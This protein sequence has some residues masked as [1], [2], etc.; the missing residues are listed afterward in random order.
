MN[1]KKHVSSHS[2]SF[3][4]NPKAVACFQEFWRVHEERTRRLRATSPSFQGTGPEAEANTLWLTSPSN[5]PPTL[6]GWNGLQS[7]EW[8]RIAFNRA[9]GTHTPRSTGLR[10]SETERNANIKTQVSFYEDIQ[11]TAKLWWKYLH[12]RFNF[13]NVRQFDRQ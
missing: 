4:V 11:E 1:K 12:T 10:P 2:P 3:Q 6:S 5:L 13:K 8:L 7:P 9:N